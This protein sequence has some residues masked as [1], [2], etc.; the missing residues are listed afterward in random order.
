MLSEILFFA[1]EQRKKK[2]LGDGQ[3]KKNSPQELLWGNAKEWYGEECW[4]RD[5]CG[6]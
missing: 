3:P 1:K 6:T 2:G 4:D 5:K